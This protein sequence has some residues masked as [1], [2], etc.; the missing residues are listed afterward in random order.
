MFVSVVIFVYFVTLTSCHVRHHDD[1]R[2]NRN[3]SNIKHSHIHDAEDTNKIYHLFPGDIHPHKPAKVHKYLYENNK[4]K[5][6]PLTEAPSHF[7]Y[8]SQFVL[9]RDIRAIDGPI[10]VNRFNFSW[11][12]RLVAKVDGDLILGGLMMVHEREDTITCGKIMPQGGIQAL[13]AMLF[14]IDYINNKKDFLPG[15]KIGTHIL[16]DCDKDTYGLE[17]ALDF[18]KGEEIQF[19]REYK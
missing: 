16:D 1:I 9:P 8:L 7:G 2:L 3:D 19:N 4:P 5:N 14:T 6:R 17:Q 18:I 15:I 11:P 13:E 10:R 12:T